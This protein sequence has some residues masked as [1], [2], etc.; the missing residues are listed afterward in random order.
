ML[1]LDLTA[2]PRWLDLAHGVRLRVAPLTT[3]LMVAS[4][5][6]LRLVSS[7]GI[8]NAFQG[9]E[10]LIA[11]FL[12]DF[13][14][15][16]NVVGAFLGVL[17]LPRLLAAVGVGAVNLA[18]A[19][20][21]AA[22][23]AAALVAP[24]LASAAGA[25][26][27]EM[28]LKDAIKTPLSALFYGA[29]PPAERAPARA[30]VFGAVIPLATLAAAAGLE[31]S[32]RSADPLAT[33]AA[34]GLGAALLFVAASWQQNRAW[35]TRLRELLDWSLAREKS[36]GGQPDPERLATAERE[37]PSE[38]L[39]PIARALASPDRRLRAVAEEVLAETVE[40]RAA[41]RIARALDLQDEKRR[42]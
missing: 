25:R 10:D 15:L 27:V 33:A 38:E 6:A 40:R 19:I 17:V 24:S 5:Y 41:H 18:Y 23:P 12:G 28:A 26:F 37:L 3:A 22:A 2:E 39:A 32:R 9:D 11:S 21:T 35:R 1:R 34:F 20:A 16:S 13:D 29:E 4:R 14:A 7:T 30:L 36:R 31:V 8:E 42:A